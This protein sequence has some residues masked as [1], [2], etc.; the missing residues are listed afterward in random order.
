MDLSLVS[1]DQ[2]G[3]SAQAT[4]TNPA[5]QIVDSNQYGTYRYLVTVFGNMYRYLI[6]RES[7]G[8]YRVPV[9]VK[10]ETNGKQYQ[11]NSFWRKTER[12][13]DIFR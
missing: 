5:E 13:E 4:C 1:L 10:V 6:N 11:H 9:V 7:V 8:R 2:A 3:H 12:K